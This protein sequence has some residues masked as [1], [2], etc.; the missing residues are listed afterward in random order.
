MPRSKHPIKV[1]LCYARV[2]SAA[3][4]T[5]Y[6]RLRRYGIDT[7]LDREKLLPGQDWEYEISKAVR[8]AD[9]V[10]ICLSKRFNREGFQQKEVRLALDI[11][12][13]KP[14]GG[15]FII[16]ARLEKCDPPE[17]L[18]RWQR[19]DLFKAGG[20]QRLMHTLRM[21]L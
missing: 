4:H 1:F 14:D 8:E 17:S 15:I 13:E 19:V 11:A 20:Y 3:V 10:I 5:L 16:P 6:N 12:K 21:H 9:L 2:D 18:R 7:W